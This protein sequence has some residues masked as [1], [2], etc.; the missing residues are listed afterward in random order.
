MQEQI[1]AGLIDQLV[2]GPH[3]NIDW[4]VVAERQLQLVRGSVL[5][6]SF[7]YAD[8]QLQLVGNPVLV[9]EEGKRNVLN[10]RPVPIVG[11]PGME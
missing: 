6:D 3:A 5:N 1:H 9:R 7:R 8:R 11:N 4:K 2:V 10:Q